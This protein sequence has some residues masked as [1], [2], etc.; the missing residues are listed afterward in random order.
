M[1]MSK[2]IWRVVQGCKFVGYVE[3][4]HEVGALAQAQKLFGSNLYVEKV[5]N[6]DDENL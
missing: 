4:L 3:H 6:V 1:M 5:E 2:Y